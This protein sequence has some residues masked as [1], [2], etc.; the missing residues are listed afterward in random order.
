M[1][2]ASRW[3]RRAARCRVGRSRT[4][5]PRDGWPP[6]A[7]AARGLH[8]QR[9]RR[10][11]QQQQ[12]QQ[13]QRRHH[14]HP[15]HHPLRGLP[16]PL[17][18]CGRRHVGA[19]RCGPWR[20]HHAGAYITAARRG[21]AGAQHLP[22]RA[23]RPPRQRGRPA[24][25]GGR[26][27]AGGACACGR[28]RRSVGEP[29]ACPTAPCA[30]DMPAALPLHHRQPAAQPLPSRRAEHDGA[31]GPETRP[32]ASTGAAVAAAA[33][34]AGAAAVAEGRPRLVLRRRR[35]RRNGLLPL[36]S[37]LMSFPSGLMSFPS[38]VV[39]VVVAVV[40]V[41]ASRSFRSRSACTRAGC[42]GPPSLAGS[43][44]HKLLRVARHSLRSAAFAPAPVQVLFFFDTRRPPRDSLGRRGGASEP[45]EAGPARAACSLTIDDAPTE[46][47]EELLDVLKENGVT[48]TFFIISDLGRARREVVKRMLREGHE[49]AN[50]YSIDT[51]SFR[52][53]PEVFE[54]R[55]LDCERFINEVKGEVAAEETDGETAPEV[56]WFRPGGGF[57]HKG[58]YTALDR[59]RYQLVL[60]NVYPWDAADWRCVL[61]ASRGP[62]T[63]SAQAAWRGP[64]YCVGSCRARGQGSTPGI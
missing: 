47:T 9:R 64:C 12:Q 36:P 45:A 41:V 32:P 27:R 56:K 1:P 38:V 22:L 10:Q 49:I 60:G 3:A 61:A 57:F 51:K 58:M 33:A 46:H 8:Q 29:H 59:H 54:A 55:L 48:A 13:Q 30:G 44:Y 5:S 20:R 23:A 31:D 40:T 16:G 39:A 19:A 37:G 63:T 11:Q 50:H 6:R 52:D 15:H 62:G 7:G 43:T 26:R 25:L 14:P 53:P 4:R 24:V 34:A 17:P 28:A 42:A 2:A 21:P 18:G 35:L